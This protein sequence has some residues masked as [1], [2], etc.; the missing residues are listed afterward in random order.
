[1][2]ENG[3]K[4]IDVVVLRVMYIMRVSGILSWKKFCEYL[5][6]IWFEFNPYDP[7]VANRIKAGNKHTVILHVD[8]II[9]SHVNSK[10]DAKFKEYINSNYAKHGEVKVNREKVHHYLGGAFDIA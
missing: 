7:C 4:L 10:V 3:K 9:S 8:D 5:E 2:Y 6:N 1:M